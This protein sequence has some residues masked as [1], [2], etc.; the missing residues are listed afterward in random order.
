LRQF[1][2]YVLSESYSE[3]VLEEGRG[4]VIIDVGDSEQAPHQA[5]DNR[6]YGRL[7]GKSLPLNHRFISDIFYRRRDPLIELSFVIEERWERVRSSTAFRSYPWNTQ[8]SEPEFAD[9]RTISIVV[10]AT[11]RGR[12]YAQYINVIVDIP[13]VLIMPKDRDED[14]IVTTSADTAAYRW[15]E[16]NTRRDIVDTEVGVGNIISKYGPSWFDPLLPGLSQTWRFPLPDELV[17]NDVAQDLTFY[18]Q[19][20]ADN[21]PARTGTV[22]WQHIKQITNAR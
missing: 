3:L 2:V 15:Q 22:Q 10:T 20:F 7:G 4:I 18:W 1:N 8:S 21:A 6:Y 5:E 12:V 11:N 13:E 17:L 19:V 9:E 16:S 14:S